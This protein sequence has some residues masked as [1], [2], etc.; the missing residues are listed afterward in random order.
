M[1]WGFVAIDGLSAGSLRADESPNFPSKVIL[2]LRATCMSTC[3]EKEDAEPCTRYCDCHLFELRRDLSDS[4]VEQL[5]L[6][7][8]RGGMGAESIRRWLHASAKL[9][10]DRVFGEGTGNKKPPE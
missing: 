6:T 9:C 7:A 2:G 1:L 4:Q 8:E 3:Q 5:L 10:E